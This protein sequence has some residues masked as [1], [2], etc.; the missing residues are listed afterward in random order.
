[1]SAPDDW[2]AETYVSLA[3]GSDGVL[4]PLDPRQKDEWLHHLYDRFQELG[5]AVS[6]ATKTS[7]DGYR[8]EERWFHDDESGDLVRL[9][10][11]NAETGLYVFLG[12]RGA[13]HSEAEADFLSAVTFA[14]ES[15]GK[16]RESVRWEA[17]IAQVPTGRGLRRMGLRLSA[18]VKIG[19]MTL[20]DWGSLH[21]E[22]VATWYP[23]MGFRTSPWFSWPIRVAGSVQCYSWDEDGIETTAARL[24]G[25]VEVMSLA[26]D[27]PM[28]VRVGPY[29]P[30]I[31]VTGDE[32]RVV[33]GLS[34][35]AVADDQEWRPEWQVEMPEWALQVLKGPPPA[36]RTQRAMSL[37]HEA[38]LLKDRQPSM[39]LVGFTASIETLAVPKKGLPACSGECGGVVGIAERF[40]EV[41]AG[42]LSADEVELLGNAYSKR[43]RTAHDARLHG[44]EAVLGMFPVGRLFS[45][46]TRSVFEWGT[47][48]LAAKASRDLIL[49][50]LD[51]AKTG[52]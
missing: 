32:D 47:V 20:A 38:T 43:S 41:I 52:P 7:P 22:D 29:E 35:R 6:A 31:R 16:R 15:T 28:E 50:H 21:A 30:T 5:R 27:W 42:V 18:P 17:T 33:P 26:F 24:R 51:G 23:T 4:I 8:Y 10:I 9:Q 11:I 48:H 12:R 2:V 44:S 40:R 19:D 34:A 45:P 46:D 14:S 37:H 49:T 13:G 25:L 39:A 36:A 3:D 1:V